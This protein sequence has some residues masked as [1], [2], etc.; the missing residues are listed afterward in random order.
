MA[1]SF[2][3]AIAY[4]SHYQD[5]D[6]AYGKALL[7]AVGLDQSGGSPRLVIAPSVEPLIAKSQL[8]SYGDPYSGHRTLRLLLRRSSLMSFLFV[9]YRSGRSEKHFPECPI[10]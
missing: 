2:G 1:F 9:N 4:G 7:E 5:D 3:G 10:H 8:S 6:I